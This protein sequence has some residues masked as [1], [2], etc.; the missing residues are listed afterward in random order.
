MM[1]SSGIVYQSPAPKER[2]NALERLPGPPRHVI[3]VPDDLLPLEHTAQQGA[4]RADGILHALL[5]I[6]SVVMVA[7]ITYL[8]WPAVVASRQTIDWVALAIRLL[9]VGSIGLVVETLIEMR[10]LPWRFLKE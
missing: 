6:G 9:M 5:W 7:L 4:T 2:S 10:L 8:T 1:E 3:A